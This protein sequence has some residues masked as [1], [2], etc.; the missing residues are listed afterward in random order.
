MAH[1]LLYLLGFNA[2]QDA[3]LPQGFDW[4]DD[5]KLQDGLKKLTASLRPWTI[6]FHAAQNTLRFSAP[7]RTTRRAG[8]ACP[9]IPTAS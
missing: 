3:I 5:A 8:I 7:A 2:P 1:T 6:D 9:A 4:K